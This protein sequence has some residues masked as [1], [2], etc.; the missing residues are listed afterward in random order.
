M[1]MIRAVSAPRGKPQPDLP[2][3][4]RRGRGLR[5]AGRRC[6]FAAAL[7]AAGGAACGRQAPPAAPP[8]PPHLVAAPPTVFADPLPVHGVQAFDVLATDYDLDGDTDVLVSWHHRGPLELL[9]N[10]GGT[11]HHPEGPPSAGL[12]ANLSATPE[13]MDARITKAGRA[14]LYLWRDADGAGPWRLRWYDPS[15][16][17]RG[18]DLEIETSL[19]IIAADGLEESEQSRPDARTL[20]VRLAPGVGDR[21]FA[22]HTRRVAVQLVLRRRPAAVGAQPPPLFLGPSLEPAPPGD[23]SVWKPDPHGLAW[24]DLEGTLHPD[25]FVVRGALGGELVAPLPGKR[26][27]YYVYTPGAAAPYQLVTRGI[28]TDHRRDRHVEAVD[29][30]GDG[31]LEL[32]IGARGPSRN[33]LLARDPASGAFRDR[34]PELGL[35]TEGAPVGAFADYDGDGWDDLY[36]L[37][38]GTLDVLRNVHGRRFERIPGASLGLVLPQAEKG[39]RLFDGAQLRLVDVDR[40]GDL[41]LWLLG[42]G[43]KREQRLFLREGKRFRPAEGLG[44]AGAGGGRVSLVLDVDGDG[45]PDLVRLGR[46]P[47]IFHNRGAAGFERIPLDR[48]VVPRG[49]SCATALDADGDGRLDVLAVGRVR[50]LLWNRTERAVRPLVVR[51]PQ[52]NAVGALVTA[53][54]ADGGRQAQRYGS[55]SSTPFSQSLQPLRFGHPP[56]V[57]ITAI[58]VRWPGTTTE[59]EHT[60]AAGQ[61]DLVLER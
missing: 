22:L 1:G 3:V 36:L 5:V 35:D 57:A 49:L 2:G 43:K 16:L 33:R 23:F 12:D 39:D 54:Y 61:T 24:L 21:S 14:G 8:G 31:R 52:R 40:D 51:L 7:L 56:G 6:A 25:L 11:F 30:D 15:G 37:G 28:P 58:R 9:E 53:V 13:E 20:R 26:S 47:A 19:G 59:Q 10:R 32:W 48:D 60:V 29:V 38:K 45:L 42:Y 44:L 50:R 27:R 17:H 41:D 4:P 34:A 18:L 46:G 55:E